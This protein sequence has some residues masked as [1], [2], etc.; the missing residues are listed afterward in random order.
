MPRSQPKIIHGSL[1]AVAVAAATATAAD[2]HRIR[3]MS[4][5]LNTEEESSLCR[6]LADLVRALCTWFQLGGHSGYFG[7]ENGA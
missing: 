7:G 6:V 4:E 5:D 2:V 3:K 1:L